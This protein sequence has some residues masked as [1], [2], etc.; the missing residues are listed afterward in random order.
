MKDK[1]M[2]KEECYDFLRIITNQDASLV[3]AKNILKKKSDAK[4]LEILD[5]IV[6]K[7]VDYYQENKKLIGYSKE[8]IKERV[9][10]LNKYYD[11]LHNNN[12]DNAYTSQS[13][14]RPTI[15]EEFMSILFTDMVCGIK[16]RISRNAETVN[17]GSVCAYTNLFFS[18]A[19]FQNFISN[20]SVGVNE[21]NQDF[22]IFRRT[23]L[24]IDGASPIDI[25]LPVVAIEN[26]TYLD[27]TMLEGSIATAEKI[28]SGNPYCLFCIV[29]EC[30]D[31]SL[32]VDPAYSRIDQ[33]FVL[34]KNTP[35]DER[36]QI[37]DDVVCKLVD[38]VYS[39]LHRP[40]SDIQN[41]MQSDGIL[42]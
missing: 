24:N 12:F 11:Y 34:R 26:K 33:I 9:R 32:S 20:P 42:I 23:K 41:K 21:K 18:G 14:F 7:Y 36:Q 1:K 22:A 4:K 30:Y 38:L 16:E 27:K 29:S 5:K 8:I 15:L 3:H 25:S 17:Y 28:K 19:H 31:V 2:T 13:K 40:W 37:F 6:V 39:H 10:L 35:R